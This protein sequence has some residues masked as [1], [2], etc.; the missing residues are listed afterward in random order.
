MFDE[1][2]R[3]NLDEPL[4]KIETPASEGGG[5]SMF[6]I[7]IAMVLAILFFVIFIF[8]RYNTA[9][10][11][12]DKTAALTELSDQ[13]KSKENRAIEN[14]VSSIN[15][16]V[17]VV[18]KASKSKYQFY[19][20]MNELAGKTTNDV[21]INNLTIDKNGAVTIDGKSKSYRAAADLAMALKSSSKIKNVQITGLSE[22]V[23]N[24]SA[25]V[26]FTLTAEIA[27]WK[28]KKSESGGENE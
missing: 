6:F 3:Q 18:K 9:A 1:Q 21:K 11:V 22:T 10:Q 19:A 4:L 2:N 12:S 14:R 5:K 7:I 24:N 17:N 27:D 20:F 15:S 25:L 23:E 13:L 26:S 8:Y 28:V 16:A